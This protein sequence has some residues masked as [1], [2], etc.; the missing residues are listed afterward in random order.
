MDRRAQ[1]ITPN[2]RT[3][4]GFFVRHQ[5]VREFPLLRIL[6]LR[7]AREGSRALPLRNLAYITHG[8]F[9]VTISTL[10]LPGAIVG[11][12]KVPDAI[13]AVFKCNSVV[14]IS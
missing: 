3:V 2:A 12:E 1:P 10:F 4:L 9:T 6:L 7:I 8:A 13:N 11:Q 14:K 5:R